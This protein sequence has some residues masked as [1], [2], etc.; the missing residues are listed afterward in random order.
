M[1]RA[2]L[3]S[4]VAHQILCQLDDSPASQLAL[5]LSGRALLE[6]GL[7]AVWQHADAQKLAK[8]A[9]AGVIEE[10]M[11]PDGYWIIVRVAEFDCWIS[12]LTSNRR[13]CPALPP[14]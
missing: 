7:Q 3:I 1:H 9:P 8:T 10:G 14:H 2:W 12:V 5:A 13:F 11:T 4:E 6:V